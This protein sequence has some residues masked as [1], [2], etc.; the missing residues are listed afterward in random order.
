MSHLHKGP[1]S[2]T[3]P[4][5]I[6]DPGQTLSLDFTDSGK[7]DAKLN[8]HIESLF[9]YFRYHRVWTSN[10]MAFMKT[11]MSAIEL[12]N[13]GHEL[14]L[15]NI[16]FFEQV[17]KRLKAIKQDW[18]CISLKRSLEF[19]E[20]CK[21]HW[22]RINKCFDHPNESTLWSNFAVLP[23]M[24][25][26]HQTYTRIEENL[27]LA[28]SMGFYNVTRVALLMILKGDDSHEDGTIPGLSVFQKI[29]NSQ[30]LHN[31]TNTETIAESSRSKK[32]TRSN[33]HVPRP[34]KK[35]RHNKNTTRNR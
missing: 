11:G 31:K 13:K 30:S 14:S 8:T 17:S 19:C 22:N 20:S 7:A 4:R 18:P 28:M 16:T 29:A 2:G 9:A 26:D 34:L 12:L 23:E 3:P 24:R 10:T 1:S 15:K 5:P 25:Q 6:P 27:I 32:R 35:R 33:H 21:R